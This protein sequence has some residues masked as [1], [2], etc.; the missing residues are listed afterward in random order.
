MCFARI[1]SKKDGSRRLFLAVNFQFL[2]AFAAA[3]FAVRAADT[4]VSALFGFDHIDD[5]AAKDGEQ[6]NDE[7]ERFHFT[8]AFSGAFAL[9][10]PFLQRETI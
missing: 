2:V 1:E 6:E 9:R 8:A 3:V 10:A 5:R 7:N 4:F